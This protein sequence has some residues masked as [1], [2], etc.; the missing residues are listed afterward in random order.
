MST[1]RWRE[2][3]RLFHEA[4]ERPAAERTAFLDAACAGDEELRREVETLARSSDQ[5]G[6]FIEHPP[7]EAVAPVPNLR[8]DRRP[9]GGETTGAH[10]TPLQPGAT[11]SH[12]RVLEKIGVGGMGEVWRARDTQLN[13]D[14]ALKVLPEILARDPELMARFKREAQVLASLNHPN[15]AAIHGFEESG[16]VHALVMEL[17]EG[18]TLAERL[19]SGTMACDEALP[20]AK[21]IAD[22]LEYAHEKGIIHRDLKPANIN[23]T[24]GGTAKLLDFGLA[25][26]LGGDAQGTATSRSPASGPEL[27]VTPTRTGLILGTASYM[28]PEQAR[29]K[30]VDRRADI[31]AFGCVLYEML[32][33]QPV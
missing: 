1:D 4:L 31:W 21:Q 27:S 24:P 10:R 7:L 8:D 28:S 9:S 26:A 15:I 6:S 5:A 18:P 3:E 25:K 20:L 12:F 33:G 11:V 19:K 30:K 14:V 29:G 2:I 16:G 32:M 22:A 17:A 13:R 23:I